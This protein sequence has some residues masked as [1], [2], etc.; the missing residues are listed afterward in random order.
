MQTVLITGANR[1]IGLALVR[2]Y[3]AA[4][5]LVLAGCRRPD[6]AAAGT[7]TGPPALSAAP[8]QPPGRLEWLP[9][10]VA[11][12]GSIRAAAASCGRLTKSIDL[13]INNAGVGSKSLPL[14]QINRDELRRVFD[15]NA[16]APLAVTQAFLPYLRLGTRPVLVNVSSI[17]GSI[18]S[19]DG[20][21]AWAS[22]AYNASKAALNMISRMLSFELRPIGIAVLN[23]HP[24]W[25]ATDLGGAEAP[26]APADSAAGI[27]RVIA[28]FSIERT[29]AYLDY[30]GNELPW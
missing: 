10:D 23:I 21:R 26:L 30:Q 3:L 27:A 29:G 7:E 1:G 13:L 19:Q 9:L 14:G 25:V 12:E 4:G 15:V 28:G 17:L 20:D 2:H 22:Y 24:G 11:D 18:A 6:Q 16:L 5:W 8:P